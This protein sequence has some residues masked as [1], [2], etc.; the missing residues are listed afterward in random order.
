[1]RHLAH[2]AA[3][4]DDGGALR[5][6]QGAC[7]PGVRCHG[8]S[9]ARGMMRHAPGR[10]ALWPAER[11]ELENNPV[12][13]R[14]RQQATPTSSSS[15]P[16]SSLHP[17]EGARGTLALSC[18]GQHSQSTD[19]S[20]EAK[21]PAQAAQRRA[22]GGSSHAHRLP[23]ITTEMA[24]TRSRDGLGA[25]RHLLQVEA[26]GRAGGGGGGRRRGL[27]GS[28]WNRW[29]GMEGDGGDDESVN[30][31]QAGWAAAPVESQTAD[32]HAAYQPHA[33]A[34]RCRAPCPSSGAAPPPPWRPRW[35]QSHQGTCAA[36]LPRLR[37]ATCMGA[38]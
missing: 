17:S 11:A 24:V 7:L 19:C 25:R 4:P 23:T 14:L 34:R 18:W 31:G 10:G 16:T 12:H 26:V 13:G 3:S 27:Q 15:R 8:G 32:P 38:A 36:W 33:L 30:V 2:R 20:A 6:R 37:Q 22:V 29:G 1:M 35:V 21:G 28:E 5:S 9:Q